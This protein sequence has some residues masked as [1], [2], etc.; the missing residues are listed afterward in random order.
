[1]TNL[2]PDWRLKAETGMTL[3][4]AKAAFNQP[5]LTANL[6]PVPGAPA[7]PGPNPALN[8]VILPSMRDRWL[9]SQLYYYDPQYVEN[10]CR[11]AMTG[12][13]MARWLLF[14]LMEQTWPRLIKNLNELKTAVVDME[15]NVQPYTVTGKKPSAEAQKRAE[16]SEQLLANMTGDVESD[17]RD[18][19]DTLYDVM[20]SVGKGIAVSEILWR[21][22]G[23][24]ENQSG[25]CYSHR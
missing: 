11:G 13:L 16:V 24:P 14:D 7:K 12:N 21:E 3:A 1:M 19:E 6:A 18:F 23:D 25:L 20:D 4:Q 22:P 10:V 17:E 9:S 5:A 8:Q 2:V 15:W